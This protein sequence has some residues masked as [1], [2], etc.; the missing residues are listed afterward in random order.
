M[1]QAAQS[2]A[3]AAVEELLERVAALAYRYTASRLGG[4]PGGPHLVE[5]VAQDVCV[6]VLA[7][8][9]R[10][11]E[12]GRPFEAFVHGIA[13]RK[14]A[15]AQRAL[16]RHPLLVADL[17]DDVDDAPSPE[18]RAVAVSEAESAAELLGKL[19]KHLRDIML[20]RVG[21]GLSAEETGAVLGMTAG[22]VRVAQHRALA[23]IR[24]L[25]R[26]GL[27]SGE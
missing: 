12:R 3:G 13:S 25:S 7:A 14:V 23:K 24:D 22:A 26:Q 2:G 4:Y 18:D 27:P 9:P 19:P 10:Y 21:S 1:A 11:R 16:A 15:D 20:L 8:L 5:D 17:P 6:A